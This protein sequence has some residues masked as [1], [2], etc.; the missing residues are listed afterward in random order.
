RQ[1]TEALRI[2]VWCGAEITL[3]PMLSRT[4][5]IDN[6]ASLDEARCKAREIIDQAP[7]GGFIPTI[8]KWRQLPDAQIE[9]VIRHLPTA[10]C[11]LTSLA[12]HSLNLSLGP[13][14]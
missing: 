8:E 13:R 14:T 4:L 9:F 7:R 11:R 3:R 2:A 10:D 5:G 1:F 6:L 12:T